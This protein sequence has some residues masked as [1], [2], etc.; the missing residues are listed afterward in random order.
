MGVRDRVWDLGR[1]EDVV[2]GAAPG[3]SVFCV[4]GPVQCF[5]IG[6]RYLIQQVIKCLELN[7]YLNR[8]GNV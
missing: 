6:G 5:V 7:T 1:E 8:T 4:L 2:M 3:I